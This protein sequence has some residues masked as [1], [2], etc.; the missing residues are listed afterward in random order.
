MTYTKKQLKDAILLI[1]ERLNPESGK[2]VFLNLIRQNSIP[3]LLK[4]IAYEVFLKDYN[5]YFEKED[6]VFEAYKLLQ[7]C[8]IELQK[9]GF[10]EFSET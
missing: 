10:I 7:S 4:I 5:P 9:K 3:E 2:I 1:G 8:S 6:E